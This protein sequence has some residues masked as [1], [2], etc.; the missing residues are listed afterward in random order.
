MGE[1]DE[2]TLARQYARSDVFVLATHLEGYGM[3]LAEALAWGVPIVSCSVGAVPETVPAGAGLLVPPGD[4]GAL[5][6]ALSRV[7]DN[8][9]ELRRLSAKA[10][11]ARRRLP[12][13]DKAAHRFAEAI[14]PLFRSS[15]PNPSA[16]KD[17]LKKI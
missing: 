11:G 1:V 12:S 16:K 14:E 6:S 4:A 13:W 5:A 17:A 9:H 2:K 3:V 8:P 10:E 7:M 15:G